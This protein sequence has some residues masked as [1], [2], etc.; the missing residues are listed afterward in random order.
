MA[1]DPVAVADAHAGLGQLQL[2]VAPLRAHTQL[3]RVSCKRFAAFLKRSP[4]TATA[5]DIRRFGPQS[6]RLYGANARNRCAML[7][8]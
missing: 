5:E 3:A 6:A 4:D 8:L 1:H 2:D 7:E